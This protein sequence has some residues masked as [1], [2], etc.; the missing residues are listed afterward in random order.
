MNY[1]YLVKYPNLNLQPTVLKD[2]P[3]KLLDSA[4]LNWPVSE[5][6]AELFTRELKPYQMEQLLGKFLAYPDFD[7]VSWLKNSNYP[8]ILLEFCT[9]DYL[10]AYEAKRTDIGS[11]NLSFGLAC[12]LYDLRDLLNANNFSLLTVLGWVRGY[13]DCK[14]KLP[15]SDNALLDLYEGHQKFMIYLALC[16]EIYPMPDVVT[17]EKEYKDAYKVVCANYS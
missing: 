16:S 11:V 4:I 14:I 9:P 15:Y 17:G 12:G 1:D 5:H 8:A 7:L 3:N 10:T 2:V 13:V 6:L